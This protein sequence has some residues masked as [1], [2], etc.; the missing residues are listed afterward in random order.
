[1]SPNDGTFSPCQSTKKK[2]AATSPHHP[3]NPVPLDVC[4]GAESHLG[5][6][7]WR[8][9]VEEIVEEYADDEF[10][11]PAHQAIMNRLK[12]RHFWVKDKLGGEWKL[13]SRGDVLRQFRAAFDAEQAR[14]TVA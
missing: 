2:D 14:Q 12:D 11:P 9:I 3:T 6:I 10:G 13:A 7:V 8:K 1:M 4:F 5:T